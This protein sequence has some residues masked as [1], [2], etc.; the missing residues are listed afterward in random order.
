[1]LTRKLKQGQ[2]VETGVWWRGKEGL[3]QEVTFGRVSNEVKE[4]VEQRDKSSW[5]RENKRQDQEFARLT[6]LTLFS[7]RTKRA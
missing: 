2:G 3:S 4:Q 5:L 7:W 1:M 6:D